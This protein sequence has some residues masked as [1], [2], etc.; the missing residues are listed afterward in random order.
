M[1]IAQD[2][3]FLG[4]CKKSCCAAVWQ[5]SGLRKMVANIGIVDEVA[6]KSW[7]IN[8]ADLRFQMRNL[9]SSSRRSIR[10]FPTVF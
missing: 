8:N 7:L 3:G 4:G 6:G 5:Q 9:Q 10:K 1:G 2:T